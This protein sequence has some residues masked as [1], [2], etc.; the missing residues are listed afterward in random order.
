ME[1]ESLE[2]RPRRS[3]AVLIF[4]PLLLAMAAGQLSD[5]RGF[6]RILG[7]YRVLGSAVSALAV[8]VPA[9]EVLVGL[10]L[11]LHRRLP[12]RLRIVAAVGGLAVALFWSGLAVQAFARGLTLENC[13]CFGVHLGQELRWWI[14]LEDAEFLLLAALSARAAAV[15]PSSPRGVGAHR[16]SWRTRGAGERA[17]GA[18]GESARRRSSQRSSATRSA[19]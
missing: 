5:V 18:R 7:E 10:A 19:S 4:A 8:A 13:G 17:S 3:I 12:Y 16:S 15:R 11:L 1:R 14:L 6:E 2:A 9:A